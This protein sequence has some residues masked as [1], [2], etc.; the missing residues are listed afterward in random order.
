MKPK[1]CGIF[2]LVVLAMCLNGPLGAQLEEAVRVPWPGFQVLKGC[3][4]V[5]DGNDIIEIQNVDPTGRMEVK[6][7]RSEPV[8]VARAQAAR[9]GKATRV[10]MELRSP[11][12]PGCTYDLTYDPGSDRLRGRYWL[13]GSPKGIEVVFRRIK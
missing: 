5:W 2:F 3:W 4:Q 8:Y 1:L 12:S 9:D 10:L 11:D 6:Y 13:K 7:F